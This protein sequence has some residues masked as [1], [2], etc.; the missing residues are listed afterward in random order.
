VSSPQETFRAKLGYQARLQQLVSNFAKHTVSDMFAMKMIDLARNLAVCI[1][2][3]SS[4]PG[5]K[6]NNC[7]NNESKPSVM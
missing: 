4:L 6:N 2:V 3:N 5:N 1:I 7:E